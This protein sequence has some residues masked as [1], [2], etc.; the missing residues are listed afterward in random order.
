VVVSQNYNGSVY[1][2]F[3]FETI[4]DGDASNTQVK[5]SIDVQTSQ[6]SVSSYPQFTV[7]VR[8]YN[9]TDD[10]SLVLE[11]FTCTLNPD[12]NDYIKRVIGDRIPTFNTSVSPVEVV[13]S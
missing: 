3:N 8:D 5:V 1:D 2:L 11:S 4:S 12:S 7:S 6:V 13:S 9:D 10:R